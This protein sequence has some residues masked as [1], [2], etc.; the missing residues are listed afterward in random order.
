[1]LIPLCRVRPIRG[2]ESND[3]SSALKR[4]LQSFI[5]VTIKIS[6]DVHR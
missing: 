4:A 2:D 6:I 5:A 1:M 3:M